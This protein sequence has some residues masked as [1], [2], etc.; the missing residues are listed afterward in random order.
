MLNSLGY[1]QPGSDLLLDLVFNPQGPV[2]P[3]SQET[4]EQDYKHHL[5]GHYGIIFNHLLTLANMPIQRFGSTLISRGE[6]NDYMIT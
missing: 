1:G 3:P 4:L 2:L 5:A 6:F